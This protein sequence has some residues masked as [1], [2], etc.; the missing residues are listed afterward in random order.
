MF[1]KDKCN[2]FSQTLFELLLNS[3]LLRKL[4]RNLE[5]KKPEA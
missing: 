2:F 5:T 4:L 1:S 3:K